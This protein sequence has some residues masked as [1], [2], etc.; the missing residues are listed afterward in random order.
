M[1]SD[2]AKDSEAQK[3][4]QPAHD[5]CITKGFWLDQ[6]DVTNAAYDAFVNASGYNT[7]AYWSVEGLKWKQSNKTTPSDTTGYEYS[8]DSQQPRICINYY[9]AEAYANWRTKSAR[10]GTVYRLP[11]EAEWEYAARGPQSPIYPWGN[12]FDGTRLN[13]CDTNCFESWADRTVDDG[14]AVTSPVSKYTDG[15]SWVNA[16]DMAGNVFQ[17]VEDWYDGNYYLN[18]PKYDPTGP[19]SGSARV[20]RGGSWNWVQFFT[21]S[22]YRWFLHP[23]HREY[24]IGFRL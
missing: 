22:E 5:I 9:E 23:F 3:E 14:Y 8:N 2:P 15:K 1:G 16:Y 7:D 18:S 21:R 24:F 17:W 20:L 13:F 12:F 19:T 11:T 10:D 6:Y 4:E